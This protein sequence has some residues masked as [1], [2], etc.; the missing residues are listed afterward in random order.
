MVTA[1]KSMHRGSRKVVTDKDL[2]QF[3]PTTV[4][5]SYF[6]LADVERVILNTA[7]EKY[8]PGQTEPILVGDKKV[9]K[10]ALRLMT[11]YRLKIEEVIDGRA[12]K[13]YTGLLQLVAFCFRMIKS[14]S[15]LAD[16]FWSLSSKCS[17]K[18]TDF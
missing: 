10:P 15:G 14:W 16:D 17:A 1:K 9:L 2:E 7:L 13:S 5:K 11:W 3:L 6:M 8:R 4:Q 12:I 18:N